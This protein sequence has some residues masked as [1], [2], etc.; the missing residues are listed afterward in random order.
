MCSVDS[1]TEVRRE[2]VVN[3]RVSRAVQRCH[4][5]DEG[6]DGDRVLT[7]RNVAID[8]QEIP[9]EVRRPAEDEDW[10][11]EMGEKGGEVGMESGN[12]TQRRLPPHRKR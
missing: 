4:A 9:Q 6:G 3:Q 2:H 10:D 8:L 1:P 7:Q 5:L 12:V 11:G